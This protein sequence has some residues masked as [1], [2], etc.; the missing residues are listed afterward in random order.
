[1]HFRSSESFSSLYNV[2]TRRPLES[3]IVWYFLL[4][5]MYSHCAGCCRARVDLRLNVIPAFVVESLIVG[6]LAVRNKHTLIELILVDLSKTS[7]I[8]L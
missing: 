2:L 1:M 6:R 8:K 3:R 7:L 5:A 4:H